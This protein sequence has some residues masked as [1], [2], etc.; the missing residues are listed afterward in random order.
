MVGNKAVAHAAKLARVK[1]I[2]SFPIT[3][4]T[5]I[6]QYLAEMIANGELDAE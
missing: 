4:Q 2:P 6:V 3:P 5:T 1:Y